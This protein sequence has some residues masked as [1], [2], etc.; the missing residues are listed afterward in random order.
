MSRFPCRK[1]HVWIQSA[2]GKTWFCT[3]R[4]QTLLMLLFSEYYRAN[5]CIKFML[6]IGNLEMIGHLREWAWLYFLP[7]SW[8]PMESSALWSRELIFLWYKGI[9]TYSFSVSFRIDNKHTSYL[10]LYFHLFSDKL[11]L[12][13]PD[14]IGTNGNSAVT[15]LMVG[16]RDMPLDLASCPPPFDVFINTHVWCTHL[17][18]FALSQYSHLICLP[19]WLAFYRVID[20]KNM[21]VLIY[22]RICHSLL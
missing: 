3:K 18:I 22:L 13:S 16:Y 12:C 21:F 11:L 17:L 9:V 4:V 14:W 7:W 5:I 1:I 8:S 6:S 20:I 10:L 15:S 2:Y 19:Q